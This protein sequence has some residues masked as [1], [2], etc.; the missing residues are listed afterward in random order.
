MRIGG[1]GNGFE[2]TT[3][4]WLA[5]RR[6]QVSAPGMFLCSPEPLYT[7]LSS[8]SLHSMCPSHAAEM[9]CLSGCCQPAQCICQQ[10]ACV[11]AFRTHQQS[12][13]RNH[14]LQMIMQMVSSLLPLTVIGLSNGQISEPKSLEDAVA[15]GQNTCGM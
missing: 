1:Y 2:T 8:L 3:S 12:H 9:V 15:L 13:D 6:T 4:D 5:G 14:A 11:G 10:L 7:S